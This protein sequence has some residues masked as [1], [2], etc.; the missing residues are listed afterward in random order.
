MRCRT[1]PQPR[2]ED[3]EA[4]VFA[5]P[6]ERDALRWLPSLPS[7]TDRVLDQVLQHL[8]RQELLRVVERGT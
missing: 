6:W 2:V 1:Q 8:P 7:L 4:L 3:D 5:E